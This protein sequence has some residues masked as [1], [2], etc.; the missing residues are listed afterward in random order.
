MNLWPTPIYMQMI[1]EDKAVRDFAIKQEYFN[2]SNNSGW[3]TKNTHILDEL[4]DFKKRLMEEVEYY[5]YYKLNVS[6][7]MRFYFTNSWIIKFPSGVFGQKHNH[8]NALLS[9]V[10]YIHTPPDAGTLCLHKD[11]NNVNTF[12]P[13]ILPEFTKEDE[14]S[15]K[16][17]LI[18]P[19]AGMM[20]IMPSHVY[21]SVA[22]NLDTEDRYALPFN[23]H[24]KGELGNQRTL[25]YVELK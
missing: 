18:K 8:E 15:M 21:H 19:V 20:I 2:T 22:P 16:S 4:P 14:Y 3:V 6:K 1:G 12:Y 5:V 23:L 25:N 11:P 7:K 13:N 10:Y 9:G 17:V 24:I